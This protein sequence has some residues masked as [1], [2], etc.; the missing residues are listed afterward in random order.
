MSGLTLHELTGS[1]SSVGVRIALGYKGL[2]YNRKPVDFTEFPGDRTLIAGLSRQPRVPVLEHGKTVMFDSRSI[3][4]YLEANFRESPS[5]FSND[6]ATHGEIETWE[7]WAGPNI[8]EPIGMMFGQA[9]EEE[10]DAN[11]ISQANALLNERLGA[12]EE[13]LSDHDWLVGDGMTVAD[14]GVGT[15]LTLAFLS[16]VRSGRLLSPIGVGTVTT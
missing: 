2:D 1:P 10:K 6:Y 5:L 16:G 3:L 7:A 14:I 4:R 9:F 13:R 8:G 15:G 12:V 11:V